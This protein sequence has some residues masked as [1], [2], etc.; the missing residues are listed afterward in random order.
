MSVSKRDGT[1]WE[2]TLVDYLG[3]AGLR[4]YR[5]AQ[6]G[7]ADIGDIRVEGLDWTIEAKAERSLRLGVACTEAQREARRGGTPH[8]VVLAK[9]RQRSVADSYAIMPISTWREMADWTQGNR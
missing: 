8:W 2:A 6:R 5:L 4:A 9:R 3:Q 1:R 7:R